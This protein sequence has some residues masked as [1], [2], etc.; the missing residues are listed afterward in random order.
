MTEKEFKTMLASDKNI[1]IKRKWIHSQ[2]FT[3]NEIIINVDYT[4]IN[5]QWIDSATKELLPNGWVNSD[6]AEWFNDLKTVDDS[7]IAVYI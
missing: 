3:D 6:A 1:R 7:I 5:G 2:P 4:R